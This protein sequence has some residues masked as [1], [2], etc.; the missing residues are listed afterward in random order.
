MSN[1]RN[2]A[3]LL[4]TSATIPSGKVV[5]ASLPTGTVLQVKRAFTTTVTTLNA[6]YQDVGLS[7]DI[8]P[9]STSNKILLIGNFI[10]S[11]AS[12]V[13]IAFR[14]LKDTTEIYNP[15][16]DD[17]L[18]EFFYYSS[19]AGGYM[20]ASIDYLDSPSSTSQVTYKVQSRVYISGSAGF[21][22][23]GA[24]RNSTNSFVAM[25]VAD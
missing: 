1:A 17:G 7:I 15:S 9:L 10:G 18:G 22:I 23:A 16:V 24:T 5:S 12:N 8:T 11:T 25:E 14:F 6:S 13:G 21:G 19:G 2:L 3:N 20:N 4:G